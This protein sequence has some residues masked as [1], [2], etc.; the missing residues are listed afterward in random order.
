MN[1]T[2]QFLAL[3]TLVFFAGC[4]NKEEAAIK[5]V[6]LEDKK[7]LEDFKTALSS[8]QSKTERLAS[9]KEYFDATE[10]ISL[11]DC[12][13]DFVNAYIN[14][15]EQHYAFGIELDAAPSVVSSFMTGFMEGFTGVKHEG[16]DDHNENMEH[17]K[18]RLE[19]ALQKIESILEERKIDGS[20]LLED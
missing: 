6:L 10:K 19:L 14:L 15:R 9:F 1:K 18:M 7:L 11:H 8:K 16:K 13:E 5:R 4:G 20:F 12:P 2:I 17:A 3:L